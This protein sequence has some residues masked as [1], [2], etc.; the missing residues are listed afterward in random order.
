[1]RSS[2]PARRAVRVMGLA[3]CPR[4]A[5][6]GLSCGGFGFIRPSRP[7][8]AV[9]ADGGPLAARLCV[10]VGAGVPEPAL[11]WR[12]LP[13]AGRSRAAAFLW[14]AFVATLLLTFGHS[15]TAVPAASA[16]TMSFILPSS[17]ALMD[18]LARSEGRWFRRSSP[19]PASGTG[20]LAI[21]ANVCPKMLRLQVRTT[22]AALGPG[23]LGRRRLPGPGTRRRSLTDCPAPSVSSARGAHDEADGGGQSS[24]D[25]GGA[26][27]RCPAPAPRLHALQA[28]QKGQGGL[29]GRP[30]RRGR[31]EAD[32][33]LRRGP[34]RRRPSRRR[35]DGDAFLLLRGSRE[36]RVCP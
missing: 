36:C 25:G 15:A 3:P 11:R 33:G 16:S 34:S 17:G 10:S 31:A 4:V 20:I 1:M 27:G 24:P 13:L 6:E 29:H 35:F 18:V 2:R 22:E 7:A 32:E 12:G 9:R 21:P 26:A 30:R 28:V 14:P 19:A 5:L 8:R 23:A